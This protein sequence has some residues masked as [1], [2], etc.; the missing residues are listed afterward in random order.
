MHAI[1]LLLT[2]LVAGI[3]LASAM[4]GLVAAQLPLSH[5]VPTKCVV[6]KKTP[7]R[8]LQLYI[9]DP[10][11][12]KASDTRPAMVFFHGGGWIGGP[13]SQFYSQSANLARRGMVA[14]SVDYRVTA[15]DKTSPF[16]SVRDA[17]SAMR[18]I[19]AHAKELGINPTQIAAGG[20]S[21][22]GQLAAA[23]ATLTASWTGDGK[24]LDISP[25]PNAL[26]L[27][28]PVIDNGP[29]GYGYNR[30][31]AKWRTFSPLE[32]IKKGMPPTLVM[33]GTKDQLIPMKTAESF[34]QKILDVKSRCEL[35]FFAGQM[36]GF[37]NY[38]PYRG[39]TIALMDDFLRSLRYL[40]STHVGHYMHR[41]KR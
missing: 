32:N 37:F 33:L 41:Q 12:W 10:A 6:Y 25:R 31:K 7:Q 1:K 14:I 21:A 38:S 28:N 9:F 2:G 26:V 35:V 24:Y 13:V 30:V 15:R 17:F 8:N 23:L 20:G 19:R 4:P 5:L 22:G 29:H 11:G 18:W 16:Q 36:H 40:P 34:R 39:E 27:F 3:L